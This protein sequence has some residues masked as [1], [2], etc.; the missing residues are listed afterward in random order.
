MKGD[1]VFIDIETTGLEWDKHT[2]IEIAYV[3]QEMEVPK[4]IIPW[5]YDPGD[6]SSPWYAA[7]TK[8]MEINKFFG[9]YDNGVKRSSDEGIAHFLEVVRDSTIVGANIRFDA[10][11]IESTLELEVEPWH[12]RLWDITS[13]SAGIFGLDHL[14]GWSDTKKRIDSISKNRLYNSAPVLTTTPD[15]SAAADCQSVKECFNWLQW[16]SQQM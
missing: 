6:Y 10:R 5:S 14:E 9:R 4:V 8:A 15:H 1:L 13:Y 16:Y 7:D 12:Y 2:A 11:F 3:T